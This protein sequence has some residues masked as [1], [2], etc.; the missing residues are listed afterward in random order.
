[1]VVPKKR[2]DIRLHLTLERASDNL[3]QAALAH[4]AALDGDDAEKMEETE[5]L[6]VDAADEYNH[7]VEG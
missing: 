7:L 6:L 3:L 1:M 2:A 5:R 4:V